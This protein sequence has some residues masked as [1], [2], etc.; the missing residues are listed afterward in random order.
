MGRHEVREKYRSE[1]GRDL[2][3]SLG[4]NLETE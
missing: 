3:Y 2:S 4:L 1:G